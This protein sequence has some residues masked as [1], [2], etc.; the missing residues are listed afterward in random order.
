MIRTTSFVLAVA[1]V[2]AYMLSSSGAMEDRQPLAAQGLPGDAGARVAQPDLALGVGDEPMV[3]LSQREIRAPKR[4][5]GGTQQGAT[6][7]RQMGPTEQEKERWLEQAR[8]NEKLL[9]EAFQSGDQGRIDAA[10]QAASH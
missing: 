9:I 2:T 7:S 10:L 1:A 6:E 4:S 3:D 5:L 8:M